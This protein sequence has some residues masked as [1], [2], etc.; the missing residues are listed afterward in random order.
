MNLWYE[1]FQPSFGK[2]GVGTFKK[3]RE[4]SGT[5]K[6]ILLAACGWGDEARTAGVL[7]S[8]RFGGRKPSRVSSLRKM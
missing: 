4:K 2:S 6:P 3:L 8:V 5:F 1:G 7:E